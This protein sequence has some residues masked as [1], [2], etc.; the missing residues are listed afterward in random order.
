[1]TSHT[2]ITGRIVT[3]TH[4]PGRC[5]EPKL[6]SPH[7]L[8]VCG[9]AATEVV[10]APDV[11]GRDIV[12]ECLCDAHGGGAMATARVLRDWNVAA[13]PSVGDEE[14]VTEA[15]TA[16]LASQHVYVVV[17]PENGRWLAAL[18]IGS[19]TQQV[20]R[21]DADPERARKASPEHR[22]Q[23]ARTRRG[24]GN[25]W[26]TREEAMSAGMVA[27]RAEVDRDVAEITALRGGTLAW[28][29]PV[30]PRAEP[31]VL[32]AEHGQSAYAADRVARLVAALPSCIVDRVATDR[33]NGRDYA[34]PMST[35]IAVGRHE[36]LVED[37][38]LVTLDGVNWS[39]RSVDEI[40][41]AVRQ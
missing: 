14:A 27:W 23:H 16:T 1:M 12:R 33:S 7:L 36:I 20:R 30:A 13:P 8:A 25:S 18:G 9:A 5:A 4:R 19:H 21:I 26:A 22:A 29:M 28:G 38:D 39:P 37:G 3:L 31:I 35:R 24:G 2:T 17:R 6:A 40:V 34:K 11:P 41:S 15:G 32:V 10:C